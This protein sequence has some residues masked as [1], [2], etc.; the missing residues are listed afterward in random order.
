MIVKIDQLPHKDRNAV[1]YN[2]SDIP[3]IGLICVCNS[4][5]KYF[6]LEERVKS[7]LNPIRIR[8]NEYSC[9]EIFDII[10]RR[11]QNALGPFSFNEVLLQKIAQFAHG[12][13]R[14]ALQ[15]LKNAAYLA[16]RDKKRKISV[17]H[18]ERSWNSAK[19]SKK[20]FVLQKL[21]DHHRLLYKLIKK[22]NYI[23]SGDL[24][25]LYLKTCN[26]W[27]IRPIAVR[28][29]PNYCNKLTELGLIQTKRAAIQ[30]KVREF[31][32]VQ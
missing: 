26:S 12:D 7:R 8:F 11:A 22:K 10:N 18:V 16:E 23:L 4:Q 31:S 15:T 5:Y 1:L 25:R 6:E 28:T 17:R 19:D 3:T 30:G 27:K 13:A 9:F 21:T 29:Y 20:S 24:W 14:I 32:V 2:L